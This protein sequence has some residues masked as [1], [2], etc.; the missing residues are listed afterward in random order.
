MKKE[1]SNVQLISK[2]LLKDNKSASSIADFVEKH[3]AEKAADL[4]SQQRF[5]Y[6]LNNFTA[7]TGVKPNK[8]SDFFG[9]NLAVGFSSSLEFTR[10][11]IDTG[12]VYE[13]NRNLNLPVSVIASG[14]GN[15][16]EKA[17]SSSNYDTIKRAINKQDNVTGMSQVVDL[18]SEISVPKPVSQPKD[19]DFDNVHLKVNEPR[20]PLK[21]THTY[22]PR[23]STR[24]VYQIG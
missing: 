4:E 17:E 23:A 20:L 1:S 2:L 16:I 14:V 6:K 12:D 24:I 10:S 15:A 13:I 9:R 21:R 19:Y 5:L 22:Q 18:V 8:S 3:R 11:K 7:H